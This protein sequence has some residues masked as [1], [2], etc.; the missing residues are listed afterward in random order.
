MAFHLVAF[1]SENQEPNIR[2]D[3]RPE[4]YDLKMYLFRN[5]LNF[6]PDELK[7]LKNLCE[8]IISAYGEAWIYFSNNT[9]VPYIDF[10]FLKLVKR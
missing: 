8:F 9:G 1:G 7:A 5:Q 10:E 3:G 2:F 6:F 4:L